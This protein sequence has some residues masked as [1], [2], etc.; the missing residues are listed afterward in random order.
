MQSQQD[1]IRA[2]RAAS[3]AAI[4]ARDAARV[5]ACMLEDVTVSVA[6]GPVL[7]GREA[8]RSA[9]AEQF[10]DR[11]FVGYLREATDIVIGELPTR[12]TERGRW[13]GRWRHGTTEQVMRG[14]YEA[15]W[16]HTELGWFIQSEVF[17]SSE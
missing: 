10:A 16:C 3:N 4:T 9:F 5:V 13:T 12:A 14:T 6:R 2:V 7:H 8:S 15:E 17:T 11:A 1:A